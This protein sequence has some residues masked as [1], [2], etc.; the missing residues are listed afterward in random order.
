MSAAE[1]LSRSTNIHDPILT[2]CLRYGARKAVPTESLGYFYHASACAGQ[3][4]KT[5]TDDNDIGICR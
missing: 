5:G 3:A 1:E 4:R 2:R